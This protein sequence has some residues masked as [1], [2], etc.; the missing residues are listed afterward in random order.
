[1]RSP[2][3]NDQSVREETLQKLIRVVTCFCARKDSSE[4]KHVGMSVTL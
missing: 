1:M 2:S 3:G 4:S